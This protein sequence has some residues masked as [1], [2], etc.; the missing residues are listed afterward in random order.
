[1]IRIVNDRD[2]SARPIYEA[3]ESYLK[4]KSQAMRDGWRFRSFCFPCG[5]LA[6]ADSLAI[7]DPPFDI[8][9]DVE[10]E[11]IDTL[12][13]M[14]DL[15]DGILNPPEAEARRVFVVAAVSTRDNYSGRALTNALD[16]EAVC[17]VIRDQTDDALPPRKVH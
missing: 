14:A 4:T 8:P 17:R 3:V 11:L 15:V 13:D 10:A 7:I 1:M 16:V 9:A 12:G 6:V 2:P 5:C